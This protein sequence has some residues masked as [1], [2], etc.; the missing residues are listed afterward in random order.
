MAPVRAN[1]APPPQRAKISQGFSTSRAINPVVVKIPVPTTLLISTQVAV[2]PVIL[3]VLVEE[4]DCFGE[5]SGNLLS[6]KNHVISTDE[7][8]W[9]YPVNEASVLN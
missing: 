5:P 7:F 4:A 2:N 8:L 9:C 3:R 1:R 6:P